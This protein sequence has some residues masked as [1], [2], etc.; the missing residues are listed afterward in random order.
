[1]AHVLVEPAAAGAAA[2]LRPGKGRAAAPGC[3]PRKV[4]PPVRKAVGMRDVSRDEQTAQSE[5][6]AVRR[7]HTVKH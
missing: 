5:C 6:H 2:T 3:R 7:R 4:D 1:M